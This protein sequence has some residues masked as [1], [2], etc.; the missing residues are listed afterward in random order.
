MLLPLGDVRASDMPETGSK[1]A[2]LGEIAAELGLRIPR[3]FSITGSAFRLF[4]EHSG[5]DDEINR[6]IQITDS[7]ELDELRNLEASIR[8]AIR[9]NFV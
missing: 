9:N 7:S 4:M 3:G 2:L 8:R 5:L 1:M 6:L